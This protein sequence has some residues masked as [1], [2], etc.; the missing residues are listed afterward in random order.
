MNPDHGA[1][2]DYDLQ[3]YLDGQLPR[4]RMAEIEAHLS[5]DAEAAAVMLADMRNWNEV[6]LAYGS[7]GNTATPPNL[8]AAQRLRRGLVRQVWFRRFRKVA[9]VA[10]MVGSGWLANAFFGPWLLSHVSARG[11]P[12][13]YVEDA[14]RAYRAT[15]LRL[16]MV[17]Q[18]EM[19]ELDADEISAAT[20]IIVPELPQS[21]TVADVQVFPS[22]QGPSL[23]IALETDASDIATLFAV[24]S[25]NAAISAPIIERRNG[26][27]TAYW[28][29]GNI[30]YA[31][32]AKTDL[33]LLESAV[34]TLARHPLPSDTH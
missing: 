22:T 4:E 27:I 14:V 23:Q 12:P 33:P 24:R 8:A 32:V 6:R 10:A 7:V 18:V 19:R 3:A 20:Q 9:V 2:S 21:W 15:E 13:A 26:F 1:I 11:L 28:Q 17:S 34:T 16:A 29:T 25:E 30:N 31:L 5:R